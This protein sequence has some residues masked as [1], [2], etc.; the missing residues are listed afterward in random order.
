MEQSDT[1]LHPQ[2]RPILRGWSH[3]IAFFIALVAVAWLIRAAPAAATPLLLVYGGSLLAVFGVSALYHR[4][5]WK[6]AAR[7]R[8]R[9][10]DHSAI[11]LLIAGTC[12]PF[13]MGLPARTA[14]WMLSIQWGGAALGTLRILIWADAPKWLRAATYVAL[15]WTAVWFVPDLLK[16]HGTAVVLWLFAGGLA[17][18]VGT[19][20]YALRRPNPWPR[21]FGYHEIF[22]AF[23]IGAAACHF[24]AVTEVAFGA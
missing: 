5:K 8:M 9:R 22:H 16:A 15:G 14:H 2:L 11:F 10:L 12:T 7:A 21:V 3:Q 18:T 1:E 6:T 24:T 23:V 19:V 20:A 4:V 13:T 17:Y